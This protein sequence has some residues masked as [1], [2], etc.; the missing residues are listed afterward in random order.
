MQDQLAWAV[1]LSRDVATTVDFYEK[2][3]GWR[4]ERLDGLC[5]SVWVAR[6]A[7]GAPIAVF[8]DASQSDFPDAPELWLPNFTVDDIDNRVREAERLGAAILREPFD[9]P[10]LGRFATLRQP[11]G[12]IVAWRSRPGP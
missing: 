2:S 12:G 5:M 10:G 9:I 6:S 8:C 1:L 4:F 3:L 7:E 11:G